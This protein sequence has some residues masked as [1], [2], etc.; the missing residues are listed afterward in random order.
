[1]EEKNNVFDKPISFEVIELNNNNELAEI[2]S[3]KISN[4]EFSLKTLKKLQEEY[5]NTLTDLMI[6]HDVQKIENS[7][8][9]ISLSQGE[10]RPTLD[11]EKLK[12]EYG[13]V[14]IECLKKTKVKPFIKITMK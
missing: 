6:E 1:M 11:T 8:F 9:K 10:E 14:Y 12:N 4:I 7:Y 2:I 13:D 5:K 3:Q